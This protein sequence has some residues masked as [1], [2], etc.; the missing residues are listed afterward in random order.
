MTY[1]VSSISSRQLTVHQQVVQIQY[2]C[3]KFIGVYFCTLYNGNTVLQCYVRAIHMAYCI[4]FVV[5]HGLTEC[6]CVEQ[7][8]SVP[9]LDC[10]HSSALI[11]NTNNR[12]SGLVFRSTATSLQLRP[13]HKT[14]TGILYSTKMRSIVTEQRGLAVTIMSSAETVEPIDTS[15]GI[16]TQVGPRNYV[17]DGG[18]DLP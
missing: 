14:V 17:L 15:F 10:L 13:Q 2:S 3:K 4:S 9:C 1:E 18:S 12:L 11:I 16:W 6:S 5:F 7:L 8:R